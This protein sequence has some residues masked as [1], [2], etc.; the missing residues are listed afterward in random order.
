VALALGVPQGMTIRFGLTLSSEEHPPSRLLDIAGL[1]EESGFDFV[2]IS[3]HFHPWLDAQGHSPFVWALLGALAERT[4]ELGVAVGVTCPIMRIHPVILAQATATVSHLLGERFTWGVGTGEALNEHV[5]AD[6]WPPAPERLEMLEE[7]V[8]LIRAL[9]EGEETTFDGFHF[10]AE[11][12]RIYDAPAVPIPIVMSA[13]GPK[14]ASLAARIGDGLWVTGTDATPIERWKEAGGAGPVY[15]QITVCWG[16]DRERAI[17]TV[18]ERWRN[19]AVP[20]Q[21]SQDLPTPAHFEQAASIV[22]RDD[23]AEQ[24][25]CG[26]D[27]GAIV[28]QAAAAIEAG[29]DHLY[30]HQVGDD[31]E[32]FCSVWETELRD[33]LAAGSSTSSSE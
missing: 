7:A 21:L 9:W 14:A 15:S 27:V 32:G 31:Q 10:R 6:R 24:V 3:D 30:F 11:N 12:A 33:A 22:R 17:D 16:P 28:E 5:L 20:G 29:V 23:L 13:F 19:A 25:T 18:E 4:S 1:A 2:S 8:G 26:P